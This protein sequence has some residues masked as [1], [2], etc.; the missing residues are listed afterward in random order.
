LEKEISNKK[1]EINISEII[2]EDTKIEANK[3]LSQ[4]PGSTY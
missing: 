1:E 2:D 4:N 3:K